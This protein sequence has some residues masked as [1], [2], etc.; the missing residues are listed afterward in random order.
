[1]NLVHKRR[2]KTHLWQLKGTPFFPLNTGRREQ[3][4]I[5]CPQSKTNWNLTKK[6]QTSIAIILTMFF[7]FGK[8]KGC[9]W[10]IHCYLD[11]ILKMLCVWAWY[12]FLNQGFTGNLPCLP[13]LVIDFNMLSKDSKCKTYKFTFEIQ[14][15]QN[16]LVQQQQKEQLWVMLQFHYTPTKHIFHS[17][18]MLQKIM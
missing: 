16:V 4:L 15:E 3:K 17:E 14:N 18:A 8:A 13:H 12:L 1:M 2:N 7:A 6:V 5:N 9:F 11:Y 10:C